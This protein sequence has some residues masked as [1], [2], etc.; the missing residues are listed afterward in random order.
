VIRSTTQGAR[1]TAHIPSSEIVRAAVGALQW[2]NLTYG[3]APSARTGFG[4]AYDAADGYVILFGGTLAG[5]GSPPYVPL[6]DTWT[7]RAGLWSNITATAGAA[8]PARAAPVLVYDAS[9][10]YVLLAGGH[11]FSTRN[12][13]FYDVWSFSGGHWTERSPNALLGVEGGCPMQ[14]TYDSTDGDVVVLGCDLNRTATAT[15]TYHAGN[16]TNVFGNRT[17]NTTIPLACENGD[18]F[19]DEP[20][21]GGVVLFGGENGSTHLGS[22]DVC[23][24]SASHW[25]YETPNLTGA[26]PGRFG[27]AGDYDAAVPGF[28]LFGGYVRQS[29]LTA[30]NVTWI[31]RN[32]NWTN[33]TTSP[34]PN[35]TRAG[36][37]MVWDAADNASIWFGGN[38]N[39]TWS[40]GT[41]VPLLGATLQ[42]SPAP[43]DVGV[44]VRFS[45]TPVG[46]SPP[47][48][49]NWSFGDGTTSSLPAPTHAY[50]FAASFRV[51]LTM[52]DTR[53]GSAT[54]FIQIQIVPA[55]TANVTVQPSPADAGIPV[56]FT[57]TVSGGF[58]NMSYA[59]TFGDG[60]TS[61]STL[62]DPTHEYAGAGN[63]STTLTVTDQAGGS[64]TVRTPVQVVSQL[65]APVITANPSSP[66]LGQLVN[67]TA[68]ETTGQ[69]PYRY[70][71]AFGDGGTGGNLPSISHIFTTNGPFVTSVTVVDADGAQ[72]TG[73]LNLT[74]ALNV[75]I[76]GNWSAG[77]GP[78][79]VGFATTVV[80][81]VPG[82]QYSWEF[83]DGATSTLASPS[84]EFTTPGYYT[85]TVRVED[86]DGASVEAGWPVYVAPS[87]GG[88]ISVSLSGQPSSLGPG[89]S[90]LV[91]ASIG[92]GVGGYTLD[93][94][95]AGANCV[96]SGLLS[97]RCSPSSPGSYQV[98]LEVHDQAGH[99]DVGSTELDVVGSSTH[100]AGPTPPVLSWIQIALVIA[101]LAAIVVLV[102]VVSRRPKGRGGVGEPN[103]G[104]AFAAYRS[105]R[106]SGV[107]STQDDPEPDPPGPRKAGPPRETDPLSDLE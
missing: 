41:D 7:Y 78:L 30:T 60:P 18:L 76:L 91:T 3:A 37:S 15:F 92:G 86:R 84:H 5:S 34:A 49:Y 85:A 21:L 57:S 29:S 16:W 51:N 50:A 59:W 68:T 20:A 47:F 45:V 64:A 31:L 22:S 10:G 56:Q 17:T 38:R 43:A 80:G 33:V 67:F 62:A 107:S 99:A 72:A 52:Q 95:D 55:L 89:Q 8:P 65:L 63:F 105:T 28:V 106:P 40:W 26:P 66:E 61:N 24:F 58:G 13:T 46:G 101:I 90:S 104:D 75:T 77:A 39:E 2:T 74:I 82:Y 103:G 9:D 87:T 102:L 53:S 11:N 23:L 100:T 98:E 69:A 81:G 1:G 93:W 44:P 54:T 79:L 71:W 88:S 83:G 25:S 14:G 48:V 73:T 4:I 35:A 6:N 94:I 32:T 36:G 96:P 70:S 42:A 97:V 12:N 19:V 27:G